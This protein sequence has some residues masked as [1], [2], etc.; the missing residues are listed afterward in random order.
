M[1]DSEI[2]KFE[3]AAHPAPQLL[4]VAEAGQAAL[5]RGDDLLVPGLAHGAASILS[6]SCSS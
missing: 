5:V 2:A 1:I 3:N 6:P 4:L